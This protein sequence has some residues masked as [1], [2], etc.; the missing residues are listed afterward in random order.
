MPKRV[1]PLSEVQ[2]RNE[3]P[4]EK[5]FKISDGKGLYLLVTPTGGKLWRFDYS[6]W[7]KRK[8][9]AIGSYPEISL[10]KA[11]GFRADYREQIAGGGRP[12]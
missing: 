1:M 12:F 10:E 2:V 11:R 4:K 3:K 8:T 5:Q 7:G 9:I 6:I